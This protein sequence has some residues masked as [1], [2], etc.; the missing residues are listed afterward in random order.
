[1]LAPLKLRHR[2]EIVGEQ[3][4]GLDQRAVCGLERGVAK[5][6]TQA[7]EML[8]ENRLL[9]NVRVFLEIHFQIF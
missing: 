8:L 5:P 9:G 6:M 3:A 4:V 1:M 7:Q 2:Y